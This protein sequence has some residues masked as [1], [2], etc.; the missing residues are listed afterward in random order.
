MTAPQPLTDQA[1]SDIAEIAIS[2]LR[3]G[4]FDQKADA[5]AFC[6]TLM[7]IVE[8]A[9]RGPYEAHDEMSDRIAMFIVRYPAP[10]GV[11]RTLKRIASIARPPAAAEKPSKLEQSC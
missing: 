4:V 8:A 11:L 1:F 2:G 9:P 5:E 6:N 10:A 3:A 7:S